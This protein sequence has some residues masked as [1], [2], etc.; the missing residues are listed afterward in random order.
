[1]L[2]KIANSLQL[3]GAVMYPLII[4]AVIALAI[5]VDKFLLYVNVIKLPK[6]LLKTMD[7]T[8]FSWV[9]IE[10][11]IA[12]LSDKNLYK[13]F[14]VTIIKNKNKPIWFMEEQ[15]Q[16]EAKSIE[17]SLYGGLWILETIVTVAPLLG[18]LGTIIGMMSSF[19]LIGEDSLINPTGVT[20][21]VAEALIVTAFGLAIAIFSLCIFNYFSRKTDEILDNLE[22]LGS[23]LISYIRLEN[24]DK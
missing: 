1:M 20:A 16:D 9:E 2:E 12:T 13:K 24:A 8:D 7:K 22:R 19:Q 15:A 23:K 21:G 5:M 4:L 14:F 11:N 10:A 3:G 6:S 18:L 17:K